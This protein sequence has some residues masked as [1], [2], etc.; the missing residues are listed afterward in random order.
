MDLR[1]LGAIYAL[2]GAVAGAAVG[3][4]RRFGYDVPFV[5]RNAGF[6]NG[7]KIPVLGRRFPKLIAAMIESQSAA[8]LDTL[9]GI[10]RRDRT[11]QH[12]GRDAQPPGTGEELEVDPST[13]SERPGALNQ[14]ATGAQ[15]DERHGVARP[16]NRLRT[17]DHRLA[18]ARV[19]STIS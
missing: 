7:D 3:N 19:G 18:E 13:W 14:G 17:G 8:I 5:G 15:I 4:H 2:F 10:E 16:E 1:E 9:S 12:V 6:I 11:P